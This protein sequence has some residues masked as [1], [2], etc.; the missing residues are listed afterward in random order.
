MVRTP[1]RVLSAASVNAWENAEQAGDGV[2][3]ALVGSA[4]AI[5]GHVASQAVRFASNLALQRLLWPEIFGIMALVATFQQGLAMFSDIGIGASIIQHRRG[6]HPEFLRTAWTL[7][8][9]RGMLLWAAAVVVAWPL[10][11]LY[12]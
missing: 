10:S 6:D 1:P 7:Q 5:G 4:F 12:N 3:P 9:I 2:P 8:V 11:R